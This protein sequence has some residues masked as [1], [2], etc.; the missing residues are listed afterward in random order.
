MG[1]IHQVTADEEHVYWYILFFS[2]L[3]SSAVMTRNIIHP[4]GMLRSQ[5]KFWQQAA[6]ARSICK[7]RRSI[8]YL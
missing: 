7:C 5:K 3:Y 1:K 4:Q 2:L 8:L 6:D